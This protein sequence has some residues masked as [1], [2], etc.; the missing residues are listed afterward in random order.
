MVEKQ[1]KLNAAAQ[2]NDVLESE[3]EDLI[4]PPQHHDNTKKP[5]LTKVHMLDNDTFFDPEEGEETEDGEGDD[6]SDA[7]WTA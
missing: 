3:Y 6:G 5:D 4:A 1:Q 7:N 2:S